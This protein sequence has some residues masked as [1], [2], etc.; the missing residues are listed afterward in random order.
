MNDDGLF[1]TLFCL[2]FAFTVGLLFGVAI[3]AEATENRCQEVGALII[4]N[5]VYECR[6]AGVVSK[7]QNQERQEEQQ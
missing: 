7:Q 5:K 6:V 3:G 1:T 2:L 4:D